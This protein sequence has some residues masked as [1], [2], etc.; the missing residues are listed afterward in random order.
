MKISRSEQMAL[1]AGI[2]QLNAMRRNLAEASKQFEAF[3]KE[4]DAVWQEIVDGHALPAD[5]KISEYYLEGGEL[6]KIAE[7]GAKAEG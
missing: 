5:A 4:V 1:A 6:R 3:Q 2:T 7:G